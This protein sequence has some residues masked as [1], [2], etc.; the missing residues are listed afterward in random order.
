MSRLTLFLLAGMFFI[1]AVWA[2]FGFTYA[3]TLIPFACNAISKILAFA[4]AVSLFLTKQPADR[5]LAE[6][7]RESLPR[8]ESAGFV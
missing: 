2:V 8:R 7:I 5:S 3:S 4:V 1:F 6:P